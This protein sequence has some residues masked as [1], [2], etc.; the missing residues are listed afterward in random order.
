M[1]VA[2][3]SQRLGWHPEYRG[4]GW[5]TPSVMSAS[6]YPTNH[7]WQIDPVFGVIMTDRVTAETATHF[8]VVIPHFTTD[9]VA[10]ED[11]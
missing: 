9:I 10:R 5:V 3:H 8:V 7:H 1:T 11:W 4:R 6:G 2:P